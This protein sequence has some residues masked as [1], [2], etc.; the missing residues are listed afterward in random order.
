MERPPGT[1]ALREDGGRD[2]IS[3]LVHPAVVAGAHQD[4]LLYETTSGP[5]AVG[6]VEAVATESGPP[7][8]VAVPDVRRRPQE[9]RVGVGVMPHAAGVVV[10][11]AF[12]FVDRDN[13]T[14]PR[15]VDRRGSPTAG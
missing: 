9:S 12:G 1:S 14:R 4:R 11:R 3:M 2:K 7:G 13:R 5:T 15:F 6:D 8:R 10:A